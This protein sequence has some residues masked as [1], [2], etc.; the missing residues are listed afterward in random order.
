M[1]FFAVSIWVMLILYVV[2]LM[3]WP[4]VKISHQS[5]NNSVNT[6]GWSVIVP[7]RNEA[8]HIHRLFQEFSEQEGV[9]VFEVIF[10]NDHSEDDSLELLKALQ[11][12]TRFDFKVI[13][14]VETQGKKAALRK[15]VEAARFNQF[16]TVDA[17]TFRGKSWI[18]CIS[19]SPSA[20]LMILPVWLRTVA[21][22]ALNNL[23]TTEQQFLQCLTYYSA[24]SGFPVLCNGSNL[25]FNKPEKYLTND[26]PSGDDMF[27]LEQF[28]KENKSISY[29]N[30]PDASVC[31]NAAPDWS[32]F[33]Q[34]RLRWHSKN[35]LYK[36]SRFY[37]YGFWVMCGSLAVLLS[38]LLLLMQQFN[39]LAFI[40]ILAIKTL[41]EMLFIHYGLREL[42][43]EKSIK[44]HQQK[45]QFGNLQRFMGLIFYNIIL[46]IVLIGGFFVRPS[47]KGRGI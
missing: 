33:F 18:K 15:G 27:L 30:T 34:Q 32:A 14:L 26:H 42:N 16:I 4:F 22:V 1:E 11:P 28:I 13:S 39:L 6:K 2:P 29:L 19:S 7:I 21:P 12:S 36:E 45:S 31:T 40:Q 44:L 3:I 46:W 47:W 20:E 9:Y 5:I 24:K 17:D 37:V 23:Q 43:Y 25:A 38:F 8:V 41:A 35:F 10:V